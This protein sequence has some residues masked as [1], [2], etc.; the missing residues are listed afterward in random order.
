MKMVWV[1]SLADLGDCHL[2]E[3]D[4]DSP[5]VGRDP[6]IGADIR[7]LRSLSGRRGADSQ[8]DSQSAG[9]ALLPSPICEARLSAEM[10]L[11]AADMSVRAT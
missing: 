2:A 3:A 7:S 6:P 8:S 5:L 10:S 11:G 4:V 9:S 1:L